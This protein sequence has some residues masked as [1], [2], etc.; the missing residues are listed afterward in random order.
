MIPCRICGVMLSTQS[1]FGK[2]KSA[3]CGT[4]EFP[5]EDTGARRARL[6]RWGFF[7]FFQPR[8]NSSTSG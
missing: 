5:I 4:C 3:V 6:R 8:Q 2:A 1:K 7:R